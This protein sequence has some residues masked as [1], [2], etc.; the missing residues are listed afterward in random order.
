MSDGPWKH[1]AAK[2][3]AEAAKRVELSEPALALL[4]PDLAPRPYFDLLAAKA[5]LVP[6]ALTFLASALGKREAVWWACQCARAVSP[7]LPP[8]EEAAVAAAEKW[9]GQ[10]SDAN[11][12]AAYAAGEEA[13]LATAAGNAALA[14]FLSEGSLAPAHV[15]AVPPADHLTAKI[16]TA[17]VAIAAVKTQPEKAPEKRK[18]FLE[19]GL[20]VAAGTNRWAETPPARR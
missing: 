2:T 1:V 19:L 9:C 3:A 6:D 5:E 17:S 7:K 18:K 4:T 20:A 16:V 14:A 12:R 13:T 8:K 10:G 11:R 15:Q